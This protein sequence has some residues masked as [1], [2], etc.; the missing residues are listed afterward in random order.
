METLCSIG[1]AW[2]APRGRGE[3]EKR[4]GIPF[5]CA[6]GVCMLPLLIPISWETGARQAR[7]WSEGSRTGT[8]ELNRGLSSTHRIQEVVFKRAF[9]SD[10]R[11]SNVFLPSKN[12]RV[13]EVSFILDWPVLSSPYSRVSVKCDASSFWG[14]PYFTVNYLMW[15][16]L[17]Q[18]TTVERRSQDIR[19]DR[20]DCKAQWGNVIVTVGFTNKI[21]LDFSRSRGK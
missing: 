13:I 5:R 16:A 17:L 15:C 9:T 3:E 2:G 6:R 12:H 8:S 14:F 1:H 20:T 18:V 10:T 4:G 7:D 21:W 11:D 19:F